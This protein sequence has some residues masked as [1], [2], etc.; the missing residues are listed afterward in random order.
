[1]HNI[2]L[3]LTLGMLGEMQK[4]EFKASETW[5]IA[6]PFVFG[7]LSGMI[8]TCC[9]QPIDMIKVSIQI[10]GKSGSTN[11]FAVATQLIKQN[12]FFSLYRGLSAGLL[13][14]AGYT[15]TRMG[16]FRTICD[17]MKAPDGSLSFSQRAGGF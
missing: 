12:G 15:T 9:I 16:I 14:Q 13:R 1:M 8:A 2:S 6:Q 17:R 4:K 10:N 7:G 11:P 5:K 3:N